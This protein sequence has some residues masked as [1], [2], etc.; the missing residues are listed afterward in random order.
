MLVLFISDIELL[1]L[2]QVYQLLFRAR[3]WLDHVNINGLSSIW[4]GLERFCCIY[5]VCES[6][7]HRPYVT[8]HTFLQSETCTEVTFLNNLPLWTLLTCLHLHENYYVYSM[9]FTIL[10]VAFVYVCF[11][12][13]SIRHTA[14]LF[15]S[16]LV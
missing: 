5:M 14:V 12:F 16:P 2:Q 3:G 13:Y 6:F 8:T 15:N 11:Q 4:S 1:H 7:P 9:F 10:L